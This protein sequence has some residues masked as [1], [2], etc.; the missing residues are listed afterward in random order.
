MLNSGSRLVRTRGLISVRARVH[1][2]ELR[3][4]RRCPNLFMTWSSM[5]ECLEEKSNHNY[6][7]YSTLNSGSR[8]VRAEEFNQLII[9]QRP[10]GRAKA[11][12]TNHQKPKMP[13]VSAQ[14]GAT[15]LLCIALAISSH[16]KAPNLAEQTR[17]NWLALRCSGILSKSR[18]Q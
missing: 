13:K 7:I 6:D 3:S 10:V 9:N 12:S 2:R 17:A 4:L 1:A 8:L 15:G 14:A 18:S 16:P 5:R 11:S